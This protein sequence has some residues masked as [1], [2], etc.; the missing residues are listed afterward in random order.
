[1][2]GVSSYG[3]W[4]VLFLQRDQM[5]WAAA[6]VFIF[7]SLATAGGAV[8]RTLHPV[9]HTSYTIYQQPRIALHS[10]DS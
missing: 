5:A 4:P 3:L 10:L 8:S 1:V 7:G 6:G 9:I 2:C